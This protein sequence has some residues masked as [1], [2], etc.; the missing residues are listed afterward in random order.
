MAGDVDVQVALEFFIDI[1]QRR[2]RGDAWLHRK[3][4]AMGLARAVIRVLPENHHLDLVQRRRIQ[5]VENQ[6]PWR[7]NFLARGMFLAQEFAQFG[8]VRLVELGA[9]GLFPT[10]FKFDAVVCGH[11]LTRKTMGRTL[12]KRTVLVN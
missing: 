2:W 11:G 3:A 7:E 9:Q 1:E 10:G 8:H 6:R 5:R 12:G 4:Q